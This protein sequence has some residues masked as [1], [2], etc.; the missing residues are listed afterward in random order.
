VGVPEF[1]PFSPEGLAAGSAKGEVLLYF[2]NKASLEPGGAC[3]WLE[4]EVLGLAPVAE[5][6]ASRSKAMAVDWERHA[7]A[8]RDMKMFRAGSFAL[9]SG[10][11]NAKRLHFFQSPSELLEFLGG[12]P[13]AQG[14]P[15]AAEAP[16]QAADAPEG[17]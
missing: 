12:A 8:W 11:G 13:Q 14:A 3:R 17:E 15:A 7:D 16:S 10:D 5:A 6:I 1:A 2:R 9:V 4:D